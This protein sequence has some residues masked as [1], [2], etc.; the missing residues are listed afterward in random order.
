MAAFDNVTVKD[1]VEQETVDAVEKISTY[2]YGWNTDIEMEYAP[3]GLSPDIVRLKWRFEPGYPSSIFTWPIAAQWDR[4]SKTSRTAT[5]SRSTRMAP[6]C[7]ISI[8]RRM[9]QNRSDRS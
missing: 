7:T 6:Y 2:K 5:S 8:N 4:T 3:K 9:C 1:G